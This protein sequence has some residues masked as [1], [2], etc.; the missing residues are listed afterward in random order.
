[1]SQTV[2]LVQEEIIQLLKKPLGTVIRYD[3]IKKSKMLDVCRTSHKLITVGDTTTAK[4]ISFEVVPDVSIIDG[5]ERRHASSTTIARLK[6]S[7]MSLS[8]SEPIQ[9]TCRNEP[10]SI[11]SEAVST[12]CRALVCHSPV[13]VRVIGEEDLVALPLIAYAPIGSRIL[14]GQPTEGIVVVKV[15]TKTRERAKHLMRRIGFDLQGE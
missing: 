3:Q 1:M 9:L 2:M 10:G 7:I 5:L 6:S 15:N 11:S 13:L 4:V 14:Y 8:G 12:L